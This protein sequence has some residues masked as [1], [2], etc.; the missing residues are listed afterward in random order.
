MKDSRLSGPILRRRNARRL[1]R[2]T[3]APSADSVPRL[4]GAMSAAAAQCVSLRSTYCALRLRRASRRFQRPV[5]GRLASLVS[6]A[7]VNRLGLR[8]SGLLDRVP[9]FLVAL[10]G[11]AHLDAVRRRAVPAAVRQL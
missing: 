6:S 7:F 5:G 11:D 10:F 2:P 9:E 1:L 4:C 3:P 8:R